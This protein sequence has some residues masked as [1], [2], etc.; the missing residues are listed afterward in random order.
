MGNNSKG[1]SLIELLVAIA[2]VAILV[3]MGSYAVGTYHQARLTKF[4]S[5]LVSYLERARWLSM[6][7]MPHG[8]FCGNDSFSLV[9]A[10]DGRCSND[11]DIQCLKDDDCGADNLC[12]PGDY[13]VTSSE[14]VVTLETRSIPQGFTLCCISSCSP[15]TVWFDRKGVP[16]DASWGLGMTTISIKGKGNESVQVTISASGRIQYEQ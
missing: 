16:R 6:T 7:S 12:L 4:R 9:V 14:T 10:K 13:K 11:E 3:S 5:D 15:Y 2:I 1:L 8:V